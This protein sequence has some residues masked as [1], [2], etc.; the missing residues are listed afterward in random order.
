M[1]NND[2]VKVKDI[3]T[4]KMVTLDPDD[5]LDKA[6]K[7][8]EEYNYDGF[9]VV[10]EEKKLIGIVTAYDM[11]S[12]SYATHLP[13]LLNILEDIYSKK[14]DEG[15]LKEQ[16]ERLKTIKIRDMMNED[17]LV[18]GPDVRVEDLAKEF[19]QHHRVNPIPVIDSDKKLLG[20]VS[21]FDILRF[22]DEKYFYKMLEESGH[23]GILQ[24]LE[25]FNAQ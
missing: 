2:F 6:T 15:I 17:P 1:S 18:V 4:K 20:V 22:F 19:I 23:Q 25:R 7:L 21:R 16:F 11:V 24:R 10:N 13:T 3:M 9:P 12:Q 14:A 8:F 5:G